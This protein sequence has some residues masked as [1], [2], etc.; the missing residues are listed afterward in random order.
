[1]NRNPKDP[2]KREMWR[3]PEASVYVTDEGVSVEF[4]THRSKA[5]IAE[6]SGVVAKTVSVWME[7]TVKSRG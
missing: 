3:L 2:R 7:Q 1:M 5:E 4:R 6:L